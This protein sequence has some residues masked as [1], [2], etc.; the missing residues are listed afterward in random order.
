M[1]NIDQRLRSWFYSSDSD[2][3]IAELGSIVRLLE[4]TLNPVWHPLGFIHTKL[5]APSPTES[6]R[7]HLWLG[8]YQH[9]QEQIDKI[10][11]HLFNVTSK[12]VCGSVTN[13]LYK[14]DANDEG[15]W[16]ELRVR[17][18]PESSSLYETGKLGHLRHL[19]EQKYTA[20]AQYRVSK[21]ELHQTIP[22]RFQNTLTVVHTDAAEVY[23]P[24]AIFKKNS[25]TPLSRKPIPCDRDLWRKLLAELIPI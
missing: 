15:E 4:D 24:R 16:R 9:E 10:H 20:P 21:F 1:L 8:D 23:E 17:Y 12:V 22:S 5:L 6:F 25:P 11:D 7:L 3:S 2:D 14:F 18:Q 13:L 19:G